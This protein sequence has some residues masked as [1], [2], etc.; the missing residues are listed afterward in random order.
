MQAFWWNGKRPLDIRGI[1]LMNVI[2]SYSYEKYLLIKQF[3]LLKQAFI[4]NLISISDKPVV[5][6]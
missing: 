3:W 6:A 4:A 1:L 2:I 5:V